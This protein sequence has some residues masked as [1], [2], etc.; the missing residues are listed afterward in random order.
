MLKAP[1]RLLSILFRRHQQDDRIEYHRVQ[2]I[3]FL[4]RKPVPIQIDG[5]YLGTTPIRLDVV[6]RSLWVLVPPQADRTLWQDP[7]SS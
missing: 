5:D 2:Q 3:Q 7:L 6:P 4:S 1:L